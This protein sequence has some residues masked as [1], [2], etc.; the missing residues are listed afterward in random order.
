MLKRLVSIVFLS[1]LAA[2]LS[3]AQSFKASVSGGNTVEVG[4]VF[5]VEFEASGNDCSGFR[6]DLNSDGYD[7][8]Y[9]PSTSQ[10]MQSNSI[11]G[12]VTVTRSCTYTYTLKAL[13]EGTY[14][15]PAATVT[16]D[17]KNY[18]SKEISLKVIPADPNR[19]QSQSSARRGSSSDSR[20]TSINK[21][22]ILLGVD[23]SKTTVYE[24]EALMATL[25]LYSRN[26]DIS[27][28]SDAKWPEMN[29][30]S[31]DEVELKDQQAS[32][33]QYHGGNYR[34]YPL[35]QWLL[36]PQRS[37]EIPISS[38][39]MNAIARVYTVGRGFFGETIGTYQ[40]VQVPLT[41]PERKVKVLPLPAGK[42]A[43]YMNAVGDF[44]IKG[45]LTSDH[46]K[47]NDAIIYRI[48]IEGTGNLKYVRDPQPE[49]PADFEVY[50]PKSE[51]KS[52][53]TSSGISGK[54]TIEYT[55]IP[56]FG[57]SFQIP[58]VEF[59]Y[60][61]PKSAQYKT[62]ST[63]SFTLEV[64]KGANEG[65][66]GGKGGTTDYSGTTQERIKVLGSDIRYIHPIDASSLKAD[67]KPL[68]ATLL[69]WML[70]L[71]P[72]FV[73]LVLTIIYRRQLKLN[74]DVEGQRTRK[75]NKVAGRRLRAAA[76]ALKAKK[77]IEFYEAVHKAMM[78]YVADKMNIKLSDLTTDSIKEQLLARK[79]NDELVKQCVDVLQTCEFARYAPSA[80]S[81]VMDKLYAEAA[82]TID[83]L[84]KVL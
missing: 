84:E 37:G 77:E 59:S 17:G 39:S 5:K 54:K 6:C 14:T 26:H 74:A 60:F 46:V 68:F 57:G 15:I 23:L 81:Q 70:L 38:A 31:M 25:K 35:R 78:G 58:A 80:D 28:L 3:W 11:N 16:I 76:D 73:L 61:N 48:T 33:E 53:F 75:A 56:R 79:V 42:P 41:S 62:L 8:L 64:E 45:E 7:R 44:S 20:S 4:Q 19:Q 43:S 83:Q 2:T 69:Y 18:S 13:K 34:A 47:A 24:G 49:F 27:D 50:D 52:R 65:A 29:G 63:E 40:N 72:A 9:G 10:F 21:D 82:K 12:K 71:V 55:I 32:L 22:D 51:I 30:F 1:V 36:F 66:V 67:A